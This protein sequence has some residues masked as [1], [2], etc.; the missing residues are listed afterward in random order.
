MEYENRPVPEGINVSDEHPLV[1]FAWM[2]ATVAVLVTVLVVALSLS[3]G[4][5]ARQVPMAQENSW[6]QTYIEAQPRELSEEAL[7]KQRWLQTLADQLSPAMALEPDMRIRVHYV[8]DD[9]VINAFATLGGNVVI[10]SGLIQ[11]VDSENALAMVMAHEIAHIKHRDPITALGRGVAVALG[12]SAIG[13]ASDSAMAQQIVGNVGMLSGLSFSRAQ[14]NEADEAAIDALLA[15]YGHLNG[16][17]T[18]FKALQEKE[19]RLTPEFLA[20]HP[21]TDKR[22]ARIVAAA[23]SAPTG[24]TRP[25]PAWLP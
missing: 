14:E 9:S 15:H 8:E 17:A 13:G 4:W 21:L 25:L 6:A 18:L 1:D 20:T 7:R 10:Y 22:I 5:L 24:E 23:A 11:A 19:S 16:A 3:A 12:L 2:L